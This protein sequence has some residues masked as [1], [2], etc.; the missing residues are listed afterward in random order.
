MVLQ[1][2]VGRT[3]SSSGSSDVGHMASYIKASAETSAGKASEDSYCWTVTSGVTLCCCAMFSPVVGTAGGVV[4]K[5][6]LPFLADLY[7]VAGG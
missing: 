7:H 4:T 5:L 3:D 1:G 2:W 6:R